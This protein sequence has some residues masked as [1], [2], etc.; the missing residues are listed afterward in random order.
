MTRSREEKRSHFEADAAGCEVIPPSRRRLLLQVWAGLTLL[1][2]VRA[3]AHGVLASD[4]RPTVGAEPIRIDLNR[5]SVAELQALPGV[6]PVRAE[7]IV[8]HR[9][10]HGPF[11]DV[12]ALGS[13]DGLGADTV[14]ALREFA[15]VRPQDERR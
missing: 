2:A 12:D 1:L 7:A 6:G 13:V 4:R 11:P 10:R 14:D 15:C 5:A 3:F 8:L 9:V